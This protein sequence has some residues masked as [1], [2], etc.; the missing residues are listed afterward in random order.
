ML[1]SILSIDGF[2]DLRTYTLYA[3]FI[4]FLHF[5]FVDGL[6]IKYG[7]DTKSDVDKI[8]FNK[9]HN[10]FI[11]LQFFVL[12]IVITI[13]L[14]INNNLILLVGMAILPINL[15]SFFLY[16]FQAIGEFKEY[17]KAT[18][19]VPII[20][21]V[22]TLIFIFI[23]IVD[24]EVYIFTTILSYLISILILEKKYRLHSNFYFVVNLN[25]IRL[26]RSFKAYKS[27][28]LSG[29][30]IMLGNILFTLFFD[31]GRWMSKIFTANESF[32]KYS[33]AISL[34]GVA[35]VFIG[36]INKTFYPYLYHNNNAVII[37]KY[38]SLFYIIGSFALVGYFFIE[39]II[40]KF[41]PKYT[42]ALPIT[43]ILITSIPG[44]MIIKSIY[45]NLYK[46]HKKERKFLSDTLIYLFIAVL[47]NY[48]FYQ[49]FKT[50][51]SISIASVISIY[52]W[53][54]FPMTCIKLKIKNIIKEI[55][56]LTLILSLFFLVYYFYYNA[57]IVGYNGY[58][59]IFS[60]SILILSLININLLF[61]KKVIFNIFHTQI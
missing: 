51:T 27:I 15:Q 31:T 16:Y 2:A 50:L 5:G 54:L 59:L 46:V 52:I 60:I 37:N 32:A 30:Y 26:I 24:Y 39:L 28:F 58:N 42:E 61:F 57:Y 47:L 34:I 44:I 11:T 45:V 36:A 43:A 56:Y 55:L 23:G 9:F 21:L 38:R 8:E 17:S 12:L 18:V 29:F 53:V 1:P 35:L 19:I 3:S 22:L 13:A 14:I 49:H 25:S 33:L 40:I 48:F 6:N 20:N 7:G 41:L 4:G 10:F